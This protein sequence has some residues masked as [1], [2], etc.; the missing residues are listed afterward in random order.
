MSGGL[1]CLA[2]KEDDVQKFLASG[3]HIGSSNLDYQ[4]TQ[5]VYKRK[6]DGTYIINLRR[7]WE[8]LLMAARIIVAIENPA[9]VCVI[10]S[11]PYGQRAVLKFGAHTGA[12]PIAGRYTPG[13]F[14][15]QIQAAFREPRILIVTDP[16]SDHQPVTEASYVNIPVIALCNT[17][18]PLRYVDIAIPCNNKSIHSIGL[19]WWM[20]SRE[21]LRLRGA[22]SRDVTWEIMCDLYF[23]RDPEEAEKEEQEARDRATAVKEEPAQPY[24][25]QWSD[26]VAVPPAGQPVAEVT[27]WAADSVK[28]PVAGIGTYGGPSEDWAVADAPAAPAAPTPAAPSQEF[29]AT[30]DWGGAASN[31]WAISS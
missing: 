13:T 22:I 30:D 3:A 25:E 1:D 5:Y 21:V 23:F 24:A 18:S 15:N 19:M 17:D 7:T 6:P 28:A 10:S 8:K 27:D 26:P 29:T 9:D 31:D 4:M 16:R 11:R 2:L 20:L 12:T 14:T